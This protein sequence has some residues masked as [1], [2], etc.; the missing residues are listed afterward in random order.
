MK[1]SITA[2]R[3]LS[4]VN[5][6]LYEKGCFEYLSSLDEFESVVF[7]CDSD[8][9]RNFAESISDS[10]REIYST[11]FIGIESLYEEVDAKSKMYVDCLFNKEDE[12][13][14]RELYKFSLK[15]KNLVGLIFPTGY[16]M[17]SGRCI[18]KKIVYSCLITMS[19]N[20]GFYLS[21]CLDSCE[22]VVNM[23]GLLSDNVELLNSEC[24]KAFFAI[25]RR[26]TNKGN[27][28]TVSIIG[29]CKR[30]MGASTL[31][32]SSLCALKFGCGYSYLV[33]PESLRDI[34]ALRQPQVILKTLSDNDGLFV[35]N[36]EEL[37]EVMSRSDVLVFGVG[38]GVSEDVYKM[39]DYI[40]HNFTGKLVIDADGLNSI[41]KYGIDSLLDHNCDV[42]VTPHIKEFSRLRNL[43]VDDVLD[44]P[45][46]YA[47]EFARRNKVTLL[48]KSA[49]SI[50]TNGYDV[51]INIT[52]N[53]G[54]AKAG[55]GDLLSGIVGGVFSERNIGSYLASC[56]GSYLFGYFAD[57]AVDRVYVKSLTSKD[58]IDEIGTALLKL[59]KL[60]K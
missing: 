27:Y 50:I 23:D 17:D 44:D 13:E 11:R 6:G 51:S 28:S 39:I 41:S 5:R 30:Y 37:D 32:Y 47:K 48:L 38:I 22:K 15:T 34:Y 1:T 9:S 3:L 35:F 21:D 46:Y 58:I 42:V 57:E 60:Y 40:F 19:V 14:I 16:R 20:P 25:R 52:G 12:S 4:N 29:G 53:E 43:D 45:I 55:S 54:L 33:V 31:A 10:V 8:D 36:K 49:S 26:N 7:I 18:C 2:E 24:T 59:S 56:T